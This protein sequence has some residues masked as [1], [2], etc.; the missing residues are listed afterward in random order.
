MGEG[1]KSFYLLIINNMDGKTFTRID[2]LTFKLEEDKH[3][4]ENID[5]VNMLNNLAQAVN[6]MRQCIVG[7]NKMQ[8]DFVK[9][10][11]WYNYRVDVLSEAKE[12]CGLE[13][14]VP[15]KID[16]PSCFSIIEAKLENL[17]KI[18]VVERNEQKAEG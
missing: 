14:K 8:D 18:E 3:L 15:E 13:I 1:L 16:L 7:A 5:S 11:E 17:P 12:K 4:E 9:Y 6:K 10:C 2:N